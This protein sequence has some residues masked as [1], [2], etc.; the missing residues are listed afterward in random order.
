MKK[1]G[2]NGQFKIRDL[3]R[4]QEKKNGEKMTN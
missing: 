1:L 4:E 2:E 3:R